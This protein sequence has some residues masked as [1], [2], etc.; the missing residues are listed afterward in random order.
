M[1]KDL[2]FTP[3][4]L[5]IAILLCMYKVMGT[6]AHIAISVIGI[7][8]LAV[9]TSVK[10]KEWKIPV[11]EIIMRACYGLALITGGVV[12]NLEDILTLQIAHKASA[13]LFVVL[14]VILFVHKVIV[15]SKTAK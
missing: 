11:L 6:P 4:M 14:L 12:M 9:Y 8:L 15:H 3:A 13:A 10:K 7:L 2:I 5:A 1:K